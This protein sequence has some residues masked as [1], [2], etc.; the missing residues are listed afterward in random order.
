MLEFLTSLSWKTKFS[1]FLKDVAQAIL[2]HEEQLQLRFARYKLAKIHQK[3]IIEINVNTENKS[4]S[5]PR[6]PLW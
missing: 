3:K 1:F 6:V 5:I 4:Q 2:D